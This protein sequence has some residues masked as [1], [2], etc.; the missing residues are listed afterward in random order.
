MPTDSGDHLPPRGGDIAA[1]RAQRLTKRWPTPSQRPQRLTKRWA[2]WAALACPHGLRTASPAGTPPSR[3]RRASREVT[4]RRRTHTSPPPRAPSLAHQG[5]TTT[6][7]GDA[8]APL[9]STGRWGGPG[10]VSGERGAVGGG[11]A[12]ER[13][14]LSRGEG[15]ATRTR[16][17]FDGGLTDIDGGLADIDG[18]LT[19]IDGG[20]RSGRGPYEY[21][22][23]LT[24]I[25]GRPTG[26]DGGQRISMGLGGDPDLTDL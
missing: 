11:R 7:R 17:K 8:V 20:A 24:D 22:W 2:R 18:A 6:L 12:R 25:D 16:T 3:L 5:M 15:G 4:H 9:H 1:Q 26:I 14:S 13:R 10:G 21:R 19:S 23:G